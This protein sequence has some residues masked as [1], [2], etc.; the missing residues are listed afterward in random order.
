MET[1]TSKQGTDLCSSTLLPLLQ[2]GGPHS[3]PEETHKTPEPI[4]PRARRIEPDERWS[5]ATA[6]DA[7]APFDEK[8]PRDRR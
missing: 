2:G 7:K 1:G 5:E 3:R 6:E 8:P 4:P